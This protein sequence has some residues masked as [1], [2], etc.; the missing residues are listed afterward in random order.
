MSAQNEN[1]I[2]NY[3]SCLKGLSKVYNIILRP[4]P[5]LQLSSPYYFNLIK[6][7]GI[8]IDLKSD[9]NIEDLFT[10]SSIVFVDYGSSVLE[11]IYIKKKII[12]YKWE[13]EK[14][15]KTIYD[16]ENCLDYLVKNKINTANLNGNDSI[17][18]NIKH[19]RTAIK[20]NLYQ[21]I[22]NLKKEFLEI[23][24]I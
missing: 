10:I 4:H 16:K 15:F 19:L 18:K 14:K 12:F 1:A 13:R 17:D 24:K 9:R 23:V 7:S 21:R 6:N 3:I 2:K 8:K 5:K 20:S 22:V 11:A